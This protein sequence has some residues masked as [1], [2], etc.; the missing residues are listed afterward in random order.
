MSGSSSVK[1]SRLISLLSDHFGVIPWWP[2]H[3]DEVMVGAI[4]TQQT[5]W[6]NVE[7]ALIHLR[8]EGLCAFETIMS[9]DQEQIEAAIRCTGF[10]RVKARHLKSLASHVMIT[11]GGTRGMSGFPTKQLRDGLLEV[12]G[13]GEETADSILCYGLSR[14]S[15][16][17]DAYTERI[18][19]CI[20]VPERG[21]TLK[22]LFEKVLPEDNQYYRQTHAHIVE[23]GK[24]FCGKKRC[25]ECILLSSKG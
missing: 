16:V 21:K 5:R 25:H 13:I 14:T 4:L 8:R 7:R 24:E 3:T 22:S 2:G 9:A 6:E 1:I 12:S 18:A 11:Y 23:Y 15:Y 17:I 10:Y 20:G 19:H